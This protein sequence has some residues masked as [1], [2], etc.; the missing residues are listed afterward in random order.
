MVNANNDISGEFQLS[1]SI[2]LHRSVLPT[3]TNTVA[4]IWQRDMVSLHYL[5]A[6]QQGATASLLALWH[7][8]SLELCQSL[9]DIFELFLV[10][11]PRSY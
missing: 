3:E 8:V 9:C 10:P 7:L 6:L 5:H 2:H 11:S 4:M 1:E